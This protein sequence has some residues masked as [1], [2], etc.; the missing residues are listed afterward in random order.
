MIQDNRDKTV[1]IAKY[2]K[3]NEAIGRYKCYQCNEY[4]IIAFNS[5]KKAN[6]NYCSKCGC[7]IRTPESDESE[8]TE[9]PASNPI[10]VLGLKPMLVDY[11]IVDEAKKNK[12]IYGGNDSWNS[13]YK[14][15][16]ESGFDC[17]I[18]WI[19]ELLDELV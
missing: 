19:L 14:Q 11:N 15:M 3:Q 18:E 12:I 9:S 10:K 4:C 17:A 7:K 6:D 8:I 13:N 5:V 1:F 2:S 16:K